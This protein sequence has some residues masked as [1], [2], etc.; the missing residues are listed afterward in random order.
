M[1][2]VVVDIGKGKE[3]DQYAIFSNLLSRVA[4]NDSDE[5]EV[6]NVSKNGNYYLAYLQDVLKFKY[7][8][9]L[10]VKATYIENR[11]GIR[12]SP[13]FVTSLSGDFVS[14][15]AQT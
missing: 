14:G 13:D 10:S 15:L 1:H 6:E 5:C 4:M 2:G 7:R 8:A 9:I 3:S 12:H 11:I